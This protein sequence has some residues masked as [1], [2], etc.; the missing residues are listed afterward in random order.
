MPSSRRTARRAVVEVLF[1]AVLFGT[2]GTAASFAP[3]G[4]SSLAI[5]AARL[6]IGGFGLL[7]VLP[8][9]GGRRAEVAALWRSR[10]G[11]LAGGMTAVS[12]GTFFVGVALAGV[13][14][15]TLVTL[16]SVPIVVGL[17]SWAALGERPA[18]GWWASTATCI[19]GL[20]LLTVDGS[21]QPAVQVGGLAFSLVAGAGYGAYTVAAK[22]MIHRGAHSAE[23]MAAA[24]GLGGVLLLPVL[25]LA[26][27]GWLLSPNG[28]A[29]GLWIG[30]VATTL[31]YFLF[32][33]GLHVLLAGPVATL[34]LAEPLIATLLGVVVLGETLGPA[35]WAGA[36]LIAAGLGLQGVTSVRSR[37]GEEAPIVETAPA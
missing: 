6:V 8:L 11:V 14:L 2:T 3:A 16:G 34:V 7:A 32:G 28:L 27:A 22:R 4:T 35:G 15:G 25:L 18:R 13:A 5:G 24:F 9:L 17:F 31:G 20:L 12:Q 19:G 36:A 26:G 29:V 23:A 33:R 10:L 21:G 37:P 30:L 1:A